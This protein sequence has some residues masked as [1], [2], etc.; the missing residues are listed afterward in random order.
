MDGTCVMGYLV[1][2]IHFPDAPTV[3]G[4]HETAKDKRVTQSQENDD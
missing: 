1:D 4:S 3:I 2:S